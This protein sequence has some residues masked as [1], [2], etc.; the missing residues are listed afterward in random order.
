[1]PLSVC[2]NLFIYLGRG[3]STFFVP[4]KSFLLGTMAFYDSL[5]DYYCCH[6]FHFALYFNIV[7]CVTVQ[8]KV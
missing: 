1:M 3:A 2:Q 4:L 5:K 6:V 7:K 8:E